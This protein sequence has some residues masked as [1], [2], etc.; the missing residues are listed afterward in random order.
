M[1]LFTSWI[2]RTVIGGSTCGTETYLGYFE[3]TIRNL[4]GAN[5]FAIRYWDWTTLPQILDA[6]FEG[7]LTP[8]GAAF[9]PYT[10]NLAVFTSFVRPAMTPYWEGLSFDQVA[11]LK[12]RGYTDFD[13]LWNDVTGYDTTQAKAHGVSGNVAYANPCGS[14]Y[15][16]R[17]NPKLD[18]KMAYDVS[19]FVVNSG[20]LPT[21]FSNKDIS[22]SFNSSKAPSHNMP[23]GGPPSFSVL[24]GFPHDKA[25]NYIGGVG[26][27]DPGPYGYMTNFLS[28][29][30]PIFSYT[31]PIWIAC[32][33]CGRQSRN[34]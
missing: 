34:G 22:S 27:L 6:M 23:A 3:Q 16:T 26:P 32:G 28:S 13:K 15:L 10:R 19:P 8:E 30:D 25:H 21:D 7:V 11:Q 18:D 14:R 24:E 9:E 20:L 5:T 4:S 12:A 2:A 29:T 17:D 31:I 33:T 1:L